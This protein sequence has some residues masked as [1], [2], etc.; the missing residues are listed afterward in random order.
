MLPAP[1]IGGV[2]LLAKGTSNAPVG[3]CFWGQVTETAVRSSVDT[4]GHAF[5]H[6]PWPLDQSCSHWSLGYLSDALGPPVQIEVCAQSWTSNKGNPSPKELT[7]CFHCLKLWKL[8]T[9][10]RSRGALAWEH[11]DFSKKTFNFCLSFSTTVAD[12]VL[13]EPERSQ[14]VRRTAYH[15]SPS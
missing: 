8:H 7:F 2:M 4:A 10:E 5:R 15:F 12:A 14:L 11:W 6:D 1:G 13:R 3:G 9:V